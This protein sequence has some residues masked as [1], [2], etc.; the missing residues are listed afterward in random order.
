M[1]VVSESATLAH[2]M[3]ELVTVRR[4]LASLSKRSH[5]VDN[6]SY[7]LAHV[8]SMLSKLKKQAQRGVHRNA[9]SNPSLVVY[10]P[11]DLKVRRMG[12]AKVVGIIGERVFQVSY[13]HAEDGKNYFHDFARGVKMFAIETGGDKEI[14][15]ASEKPLWEDF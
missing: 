10:N 4:R 14:L 7:D 2:A 12:S 6:A 11:P 15:L 1:H 5:V 8:I 13:R 9:E 3:Q